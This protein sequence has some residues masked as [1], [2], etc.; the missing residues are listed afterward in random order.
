MSSICYVLIFAATGKIFQ[1]T[2]IQNWNIVLLQCSVYAVLKL[3]LNAGLIVIG[4]MVCYSVLFI[5]GMLLH[6]LL[7][8]TG[9]PPVQC[10]WKCH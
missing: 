10:T 3:V 9:L 5:L 1:I 2:L 7:F 4:N 6:E 8:L